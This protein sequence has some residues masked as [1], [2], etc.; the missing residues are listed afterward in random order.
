MTELFWLSLEAQYWK[1]LIHDDE[2]EW[3]LYRRLCK[4]KLGDAADRIYQL[5]VVD[6]VTISEADRREMSLAL[7]PKYEMVN[8]F[9]MVSLGGRPQISMIRPFGP[10]MT[11]QEISAFKSQHPVQ[12]TPKPRKSL[13]WLDVRPIID[14]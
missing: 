5:S 6:R 7:E 3:Y 1:S 14:I 4:K 13:Y 12:E 9:N 8:G 2:T 10:T 11:P